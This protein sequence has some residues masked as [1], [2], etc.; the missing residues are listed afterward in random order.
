MQKG[1]NISQ[2]LLILPFAFL[3]FLESLFFAYM[4]IAFGVWIQG[5]LVLFL[6]I[7]V[8]TVFTWFSLSFLIKNGYSNGFI[9]ITGLGILLLIEMVNP[10]P[11]LK[12]SFEKFRIAYSY[13][14]IV[15]SK[16]T[17]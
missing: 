8:A 14:H 11:F 3:Y 4:L 6:G 9:A 15:I 5:L 1:I 17:R 13:R 7:V 16:Y 12:I 2:S 10:A